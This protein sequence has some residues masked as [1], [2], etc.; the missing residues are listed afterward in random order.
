VPTIK[1][2][3]PTVGRPG[4]R[5]LIRAGGIKRG[6]RNVQRVTRLAITRKFAKDPQKAKLTNLIGTP[7]DVLGSTSQRWNLAP[8]TDPTVKKSKNFKTQVLS[9]RKSVRPAINRTLKKF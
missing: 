9:R 1:T 4:F 7:Q 2:S 5:Q 8:L 6:G 3:N